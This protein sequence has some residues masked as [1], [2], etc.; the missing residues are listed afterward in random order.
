[1]IKGDAQQKAA[2][3][4]PLRAKKAALYQNKRNVVIDNNMGS[5][6]VIY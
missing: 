1:M 5:K 2:F 4:A 6:L 3:L